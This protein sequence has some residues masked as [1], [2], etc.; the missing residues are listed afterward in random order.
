MEEIFEKVGTAEIFT[1]DDQLET[2][3]WYLLFL[4]GGKVVIPIDEDFWAENIPDEDDR[5]IIL[6]KEGGK[7]VL[8]AERLDWR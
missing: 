7:L 4:L 6:R 5:R 2:I 1:N 3:M 8:V